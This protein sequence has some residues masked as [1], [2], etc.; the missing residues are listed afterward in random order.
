MCQ[1]PTA[2]GWV[3]LDAENFDCV[4][5]AS[6][7]PVAVIFWGRDCW[8][9]QVL[10]PTLEQ[11]VEAYGNRVTFA[12]LDIALAPQVAARFEVR[13]IPHLLFFAHG[14]VCCHFMGEIP[15]VYLRGKLE[16]ALL[17]QGQRVPIAA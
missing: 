17:L 10:A 11:A 12:A 3:P 9:C 15:W 7:R 5:A 13:G 4:V 8:P 2:R 6:A 1:T 14:D 16:R